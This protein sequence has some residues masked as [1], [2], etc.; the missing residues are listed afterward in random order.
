MPCALCTQVGLKK[1]YNDAGAR[2]RGLLPGD[3][4]YSQQ[5]F[6]YGPLLPGLWNST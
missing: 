4:W 2:E 5:A 3:Q 6:R 1:A